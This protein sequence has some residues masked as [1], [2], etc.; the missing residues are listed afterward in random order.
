MIQASTYHG[1]GEFCWMLITV[2]INIDESSISQSDVESLIFG[3]MGV[4]K[5]II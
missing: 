1:H 5:W 3:E 2:E 4:L